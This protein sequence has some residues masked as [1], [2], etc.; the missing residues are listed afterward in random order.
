MGMSPVGKLIYGYA[1]GGSEEGPLIAEVDEDGN[2]QTPW[3]I[4]LSQDPDRHEE[5]P[6]PFDHL[7]QVLRDAGMDI[8]DMYGDHTLKL[9][10]HGHLEYGHCTALVTFSCEAEWSEAKPVDLPALE[11][12]CQAQGWDALLAQAIDVLGITPVTME[13]DDRWDSNAPRVP[14]PPRWMVVSQYI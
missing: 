2:W 11:I 13:S 14:V 9:V 8:S 3:A 1:L 5:D 6:D 10:H 4:A 7:V 12:M